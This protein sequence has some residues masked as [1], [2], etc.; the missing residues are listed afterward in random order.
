MTQCSTSWLFV[1][2]QGTKM[3]FGDMNDIV[4]DQLEIVKELDAKKD[5][6]KLQEFEELGEEFSIN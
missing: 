6:L 3:L 4:L 5:R 1:N 2:K